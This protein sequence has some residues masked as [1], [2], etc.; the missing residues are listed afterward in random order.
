MIT[1]IMCSMTYDVLGAEDLNL[2]GYME[3]GKSVKMVRLLISQLV[4]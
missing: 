2:L 3:K 4:S 1:F